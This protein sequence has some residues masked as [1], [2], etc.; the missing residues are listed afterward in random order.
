MLNKAVKKNTEIKA[1]KPLEAPHFSNLRQKGKI[2]TA[3]M[4]E[5]KSGTITTLR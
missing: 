4:I 5:N 2:I 1:A 3:K